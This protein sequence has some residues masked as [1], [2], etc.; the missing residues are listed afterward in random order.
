MIKYGFSNYKDK[1]DA[2][3]ITSGCKR[4]KNLTATC[5]GFNLFG[6]DELFNHGFRGY[7]YI[8]EC[9]VDETKSKYKNFFYNIEIKEAYEINLETI[10]NFHKN[11]GAK[12][13][14]IIVSSYYDLSRLDILEYITSNGVDITDMVLIYHKI[15]ETKENNVEFIRLLKK[16]GFNLKK[17]LPLV[18]KYDYT[19]LDDMMCWAKHYKNDWLIDQLNNWYL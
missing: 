19:V 16:N 11:K 4:N 14:D 1:M 18:D 15:S 9:E 2:R 6:L 12:L 10:E 3:V 13:T 7:K 8:L 5:A 17:V